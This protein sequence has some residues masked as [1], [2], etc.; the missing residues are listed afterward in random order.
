MIS[1][2][3]HL[4]E[5]PKSLLRRQRRCPVVFVIFSYFLFVCHFVVG[6]LVLAIFAL[7]SE[8]ISLPLSL[9]L[10]CSFEECTLLIVCWLLPHCGAVIVSLLLRRT[11][12]PPMFFVCRDLHTR[13]HTYSH[14]E[15]EGERTFFDDNRDSVI[16]EAIARL[17]AHASASLRLH[18]TERKST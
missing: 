7:L 4:A 12:P 9:S 1:S 11:G 17:A 3:F 2:S 6:S 16:S 8:L 13:T 5:N 18:I 10:S 14:R 15:R